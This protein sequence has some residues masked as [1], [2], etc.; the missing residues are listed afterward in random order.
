[1]RLGRFHMTFRNIAPSL[2]ELELRRSAPAGSK[3]VQAEVQVQLIRGLGVGFAPATVGPH[4][5][6]VRFITVY[7]CP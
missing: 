2:K 1:M 3:N 7:L 4:L 6:R 5:S